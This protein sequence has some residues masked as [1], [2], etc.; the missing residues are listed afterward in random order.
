MGNCKWSSEKATRI[1]IHVLWGKD[2]LSEVNYIEIPSFS[3]CGLS[4]TGYSLRFYPEKP[5]LTRLKTH[6]SLLDTDFDE[7]N[8]SKPRYYGKLPKTRELL[9]WAATFAFIFYLL[10]AR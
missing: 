3:I 1:W 9:L 2:A 4:S 6:F 7:V 10:L 8:L 5:S